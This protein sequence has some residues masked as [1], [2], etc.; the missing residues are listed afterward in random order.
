[1]GGKVLVPT[2]E[3]VN[4]LIAARLQAD[5]MGSEL[6]IVS[7]TDALSAK[8]IDSN[9]DPVDHPYILGVT[10]ESNL[11]SL[12]TFPEAGIDAINK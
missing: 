1:M 8:Y 3:H 7:R 4:R 5:I 11:K 9:I 2:K 6:V 12:K 10:E